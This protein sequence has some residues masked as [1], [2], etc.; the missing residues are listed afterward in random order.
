MSNNESHRRW[1]LLL[2]VTGSVATIKLKELI[3]SFNI[4]NIDTIVIPTERAK[5]FVEFED[6]WCSHGLITDIKCP[7]YFEDL[8]EWSSWKKRNDPVLHIMLRDWADILLIA[9]LGANTLAKLA[10]GLCDNLLT[11]IVRAWDLK[12]RKPLIIA[13]AMNTAMFEHPLTRQHL[14][15]LTN[16]FGYIEIPCVEK[17]LM[18]GQIGIGGM[19]SVETI[20]EKTLNIFQQI[21]ID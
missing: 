17:T 8:D 16:T 12:K 7:C 10:V 14:E 21:A 15:T 5:H 2:G 9:P 13:P 20:A 6:S 11:N 1:R 19:A 18:C 3:H 4:H